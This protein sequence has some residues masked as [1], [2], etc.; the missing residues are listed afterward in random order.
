MMEEFKCGEHL[1]LLNQYNLAYYLS[2]IFVHEIR[3]SLSTLKILF[4]SIGNY[5]PPDEESHKALEVAHKEIDRL[6]RLTHNFL[7]SIKGEKEVNLNRTKI[8]NVKKME[9]NE[10]G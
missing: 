10:D 7:N 4:Q 5:L 6:D 8:A 1:E 9:D 3:K 2:E